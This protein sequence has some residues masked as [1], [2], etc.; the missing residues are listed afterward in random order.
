VS[1]RFQVLQQR[2]RLRD[3][4]G[5]YDG[6]HAERLAAGQALRQNSRSILSI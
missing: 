1:Q 4:A 2:L 6:R 5:Q 3:W